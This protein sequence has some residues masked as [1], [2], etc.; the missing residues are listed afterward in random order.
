MTEQTKQ[1]TVQEQTG[2]ERIDYNALD[3]T[4]GGRL[5]QAAFAVAFTAVPDYVRSTPGRVAA[6]V[7]IAAAF[8]GTVAAFNAF[9]EDPRNDLTARVENTPETGSPAKTWGLLLGGLALLVGGT[10][11]SIA[12]QRKLA[13]ALRRRGAKRPNTV[14]GL[15]G[16]ALI[17]AGSEA[18]ARATAR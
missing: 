8:G 12:V 14:L 11:L 7:G 16:G 13:D 10:R 3:N 6:W 5:I 9:D 17:F 15:I 18:E 4:T 1:Q 2:E